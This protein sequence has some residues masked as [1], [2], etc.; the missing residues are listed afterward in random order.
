MF[1]IVMSARALPAAVALRS[2]LALAVAA[3]A[4]LVAV[5]VSAVQVSVDSCGSRATS[6]NEW[7]SLTDFL[8]SSGLRPAS[9]CEHN[10]YAVTVSLVVVDSERAS[11][12]L[13]GP[14]A[15]GEAVDTGDATIGSV[16]AED[17]FTLSPDVLFN[18][19]WLQ[20]A[21]QTHWLQATASGGLVYL[22]RSSAHRQIASR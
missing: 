7:A 22:N 9:Q 18:R 14:L 6:S 8:G 4:A 19:S 11:Q 13:R 16:R 10:S 12:V 20:N 21:L 1:P 5:P 17:A 3:M 15:D 2:R